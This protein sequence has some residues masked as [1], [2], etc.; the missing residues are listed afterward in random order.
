MGINFVTYQQLNWDV[1]AFSL[2]ASLQKKKKIE[3][4]GYV[5]LFMVP[6]TPI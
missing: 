5:Q 4:Y 1:G 6:L 2:I 3:L